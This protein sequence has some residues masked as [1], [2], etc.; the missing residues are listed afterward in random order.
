[1]K[2]FTTIRGTVVVAAHHGFAVKQEADQ[3]YSTEL[4]C[5][6]RG[7]VPEV[8]SRVTV[9]A[10]MKSLRYKDRVVMYFKAYEVAYIGST[11]PDNPTGI[12]TR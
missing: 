9:Q 4:W 12:V 6:Y 2:E 3:H 10:V 8:G 7:R 1:M 5:E 11:T